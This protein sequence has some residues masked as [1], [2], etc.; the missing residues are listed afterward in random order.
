MPTGIII[1]ALA[2]AF[3]G[4]LGAV[5]SNWIKDK[6]RDLV[7]LLL[8]LCA[9]GMGVRSLSTMENMAPCIIAVVV[10]TY[11]GMKIHLQQLFVEGGRLM[12]RGIGRF[13]R[14]S[15]GNM[16]EASFS[17][18]LLTITVLFCFSSTGFYGSIVSG[19]GDH[20]ILMAK[21]VLDLFTAIMFGCSM[22]V[23]VSVIAVPQF[24]LFMLLF[25]LARIIYPLTTPAMLNDFKGV[26]GFLLLATS[27][28]L[29]KLKDFP[30]ADM[31]PAMIIVMPITW[32]WENLILPLL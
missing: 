14:N 32:V 28:R 19:M 21:S 1:N 15:S 25:S 23:A 13:A 29:L 27:M 18:N 7:N 12:Q 20:S 22:G 6:T 3:G 26:G 9:M 2:I 5:L 24:A 10:G 30:V 31:V 17:E 4:V 11:F 16:T 8:S